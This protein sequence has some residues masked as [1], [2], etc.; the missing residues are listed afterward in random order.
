M[1]DAA[2][3][4]ATISAHQADPLWM[5][6]AA[7]RELSIRHHL[8]AQAIAARATLA[9]THK[10]AGVSGNSPTAPSVEGRKRLRTPLVAKRVKEHYRPYHL[11][12]HYRD[13]YPHA[14]VS[15]YFSF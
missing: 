8:I 10:A 14:G 3:G 12:Y 9:A 11:E 15:L 7:P 1:I 4:Y 13:Y 2:L 6:R 5:P